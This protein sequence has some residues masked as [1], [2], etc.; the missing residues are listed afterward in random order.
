MNRIPLSAR[1]MILSA[2]GFALMGVCVKAAGLRGIPV[3]E[4]IAAR[5]LVSCCISYLDVRRKRINLWGNN[6]P[7]LVA[8]GV[9]GTLALLGVYYGVIALPLAEATLIQYLNPIFTAMLAF[10]LLKEAVQRSTIVSIVLSLIGLLI[11]TR[12]DAL[13]GVFVSAAGS[14]PTAGVLAAL[15]GALG[16]AVAYVLVRRLSATEDP[17]VI[18]FYF[19]LIAFPTSAVL[20]GN[21]FVMPSGDTW[22]LLILVGVFTQIGQVGLTLALQAEKAGKAT[23]YSYVQVLFST[24]LGWSLFGEIPTLATL[25]G[26][27]F[28]IGGATV[29]LRYRK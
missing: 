10:L 1:Y 23:A 6:K 24:L 14:L 27:L 20:L 15:L 22:I 17:S 26:A 11:M 8:R 12:P 16:S 13:P 19:P 4:I 29:N 28:I 9:V 21:D 5:A 3:L 7:Y 25:L 18:I 2:L